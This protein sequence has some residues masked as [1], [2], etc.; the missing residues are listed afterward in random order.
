MLDTNFGGGTQGVGVRSRRSGGVLGCGRLLGRRA[1]RLNV[2]FLDVC[3]MIIM[4]RITLQQ[5]TVRHMQSGL[6]SIVTLELV[7]VLMA[8]VID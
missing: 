2:P 5:L 3:A 7:I 6:P 1:E 8:D 4:S